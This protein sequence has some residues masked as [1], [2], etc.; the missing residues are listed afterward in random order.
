MDKTGRD[1]VLA[2]LR[3]EGLSIRQFARLTGINRGIVLAA[4]K[5][6]KP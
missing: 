3:G 5:Q 4:G 2:R 6:P 1:Q